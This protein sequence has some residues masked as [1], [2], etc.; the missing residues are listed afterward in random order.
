[1]KHSVFAILWYIKTFKSLTIL[2]LYNHIASKTTV[3]ALEL[4]KLEK[5]MI[6][7][8]MR[9]MDLKYL[10]KCDN[11][12]LVPE[13]LKF[14]PPK[15][16][17]Y[18][19]VDSFYRKV[20]LEQI[21]LANKE[22]HSIK[23]EKNDLKNIICNKLSISQY[24]L[25]ISHIKEKS[26]K[27]L[28]I[29]KKNT[30][31]KKLFV[32]W[33][34][35][36]K[37]KIPDCVVNLSS[38][39]PSVSEQAAL[40]YGFK[41]SIL[42]KT[43]DE[44]TTKALIENQINNICIKEKKVLNY[45]T[46]DSLRNKTV[47]FISESIKVCS[48]NKNKAIHKSL[49][50]ISR[51]K[52]IKCLRMDKSN[53]VVILNTEDYIEKM[54]VIIQDKSKFKELEFDLNSKSFNKAPWYLKERNV[55]RFMNKYIK[56]LVDDK[57]YYK[58]I[59]KGTQPGKMY[60]F[61]KNHK[62]NCP[63]RPVLS[64]INTPEYNLCK[65]LEGELKPYLKGDYIINSSLEFIE[66]L[67]EVHPLRTDSLVTFDIKSLYT[68]V[69]LE[70]T[71]NGVAEVMFTENPD[72]IFAKSQ[73]SKTVFKNLLR[74]CS[75]SVFIFHGKVYQQ[76]D[77]LS[78]GSPLAPLLANWFVSKLETE[79]LNN[80]KKPK[81]FCRYVDDLFCIFENQDEIQPFYDQLNSMHKD[82]TFTM[83]TCDEDKLP[84]LDTNVEIKDRRFSTTIYRKPSSTDTIMNYNSCVPQAWKR[85]LVKGFYYRNKRLVSKDVQNSEWLKTRH[86]LIKNSFPP[87]FIDDLTKQIEMTSLNEN[88]QTT[89]E[90]HFVSI[91]Y[92][93]RVSEKYGRNITKILED[94]GVN[95]NVSYRTCKVGSY[96]SLKDSV[97]K[98]Y[99]SRVVY[100]FKCPGDLD[101]QYIGE[102]ER[103]LF[104]RIEEHIKPS[105]SAVFE[106]I[107]NCSFCKNCSNI[108]NC[109]EIL[110]VCNSYNNLLAVEALLIKK[111]QPN[112]NNK[113]GPYKGSRVNM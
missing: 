68:N 97:N 39:K 62:E 26:I 20:L 21:G 90:K 98:Y 99:K 72:S 43:I 69:P 42:P 81:I 51:N 58:L 79:L 85:N 1:M 37:S 50:G 25:V 32:L 34:N 88:K 3:T 83:Q 16:N 86:L 112:L 31:Q 67:N 93:N 49:L 61:A 17:V 36:R 89:K 64:A 55:Y 10:K 96:F 84:Y 11:L 66:K 40:M 53:G 77:G 95:I 4:R 12:G 44:I 35:Q 46:L 82:L 74:T 92:I 48:S 87:K 70:E 52:S 7:T 24:Y 15:L 30:H 47:K 110:K 38:Y 63:L 108:Y 54:D 80:F 78:M 105:N 103:Q 8:K 102:T 65:W 109:F 19:K 41:H 75:Q 101:N 71:I 76:I 94:S 18:E 59:P 60:G 27:N 106:H 107:E 45:D 22:F 113:L 56:P 6:K 111:F 9:Y 57:T 23:K 33:N 2:E 73:I 104:V 5:V 100:K 29:E 13:F 28:V 14:K 91:P